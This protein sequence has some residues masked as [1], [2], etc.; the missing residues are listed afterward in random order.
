[1][2]EWVCGSKGD[3]L[4][5]CSTGGWGASPRPSKFRS[6]PSV[7]TQ[8]DGAATRMSGVAAL[9]FDWLDHGRA[10]PQREGR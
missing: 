2:E 9:D 6:G 1:M 3:V 4:A 10:E 8:V 7:R 5:F